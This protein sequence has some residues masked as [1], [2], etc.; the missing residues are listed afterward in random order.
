MPFWSAATGGVHVTEMDSELIT[1]MDVF[2]GGLAGAK[3]R[4]HANL[5]E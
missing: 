5:I 3:I 2:C 1:V 4:K